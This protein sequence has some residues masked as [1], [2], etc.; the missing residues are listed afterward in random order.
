[1]LFILGA[2]LL[3]ANSERN[4]RKHKLSR[5]IADFTALFFIAGCGGKVVRL[6]LLLHGVH[7]MLQLNVG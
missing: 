5:F 6:R 4:P 3:M 7:G 1:M 2:V